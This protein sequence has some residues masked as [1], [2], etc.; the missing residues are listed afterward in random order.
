MASR[1]DILKTGL[2]ASA[3]PLAGIPAA[4]AAGKAAAASSGP[5][6][7]AV[8]D[9]RFPAGRAFGRAATL[10][11]WPL[12]PIRGDVTD[13]WFHDLALKWKAGPATICG[14]TGKDSLFCLEHLAWTPA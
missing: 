14:M 2:A 1:R 12:A 9:E 3:A 13:L 4:A 11:G 10:R 7:K 6:H 8:Y 5:V